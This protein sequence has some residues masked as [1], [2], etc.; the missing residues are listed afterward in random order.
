MLIIVI[1]DDKA[2]LWANDVP[3]RRHP[4]FVFCK[5]L[6]AVCVEHVSAAEVSGVI[7]YERLEA[8]GTL[9][10]VFIKGRHFRPIVRLGPVDIFASV[11]DRTENINAPF[12]KLI[13]TGTSSET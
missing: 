11:T 13:S 6:K 1:C 7:E 4:L 5:M 12:A 9:V 8:N 10:A 3:A 2:T